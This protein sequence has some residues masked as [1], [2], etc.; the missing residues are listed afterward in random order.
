MSMMS[1]KT[2]RQSRATFL[3][4]ETQ[5]LIEEGEISPAQVID[6]SA[7]LVPNPDAKWSLEVTSKSSEQ[8]APTILGRHGVLVF[9]SS[10]KP[11][12]GWRNG[13]VAQEEDVS[14]HSTWGYQAE[15]APGGFYGDTNGMGPDAILLA[16]GRWVM[17]P[18]QYLLTPFPAVTFIAVA[19]P[20]RQSAHVRD[21]GVPQLQER[22]AKRLRT[23]FDAWEEAGVET[24]VAGAIGCGVFRWRGQDSAEAMRLALESTRWS[25]RLI[26]AMPDKELALTFEKVL[27]P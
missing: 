9:A 6:A 18:D 3:A 8:L 21:V 22:L 4:K 14:L 5:R 13:A 1:S 2:L 26:L 23:A 16:D 10:T 20:N 27:A 25:G 17:H 24:V 12:G 19:A 11:G 15:E 7:P